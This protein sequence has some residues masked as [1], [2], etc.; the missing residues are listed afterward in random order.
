[1]YFILYL[2]VAGRKVTTGRLV[3]GLV[4]RGLTVVGSVVL[5]TFC[6]AFEHDSALNEFNSPTQQNLKLRDRT[7][8][9]PV[10][11]RAVVVNATDAG[12]PANIGFPTLL[13]T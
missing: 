3:L 4:D 1:M 13:Q 7:K 8:L 11:P 5:R 12:C 10:Q 9:C 6:I 2:L